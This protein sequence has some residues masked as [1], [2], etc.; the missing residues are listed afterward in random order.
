MR[1]FFTVV[2]TTLSL[3]LLVAPTLSIAEV[4]AYLNRYTIN[5]TDTVRLTIEA[6]QPG[7]AQRPDL[8]L[9]TAD[10]SL[11]GSKKM[12]ISSLQNGSRQATTRWQVLMR[13]RRSGDLTVPA[14]QINGERSFPMT[15]S[16]LSAANNAPRVPPNYDPNYSPNRSSSSQANQAPGGLDVTSDLNAIRITTEID[17]TEAY[18]GSQLLYSSTLRHRSPLDDQAVFSDPFLNQALIL[19]MGDEVVSN[20]FIQG[21]AYT[22]RKQTYVVFPNEPGSFI[23]EPPLF[24]GTLAN[25]QYVEVLGDA[26][27]LS[28]LP[29]ANDNS[30]GY[31]LPA[32]KLTIQDAF[33]QPE[34]LIAGNSITRTIT[35]IAQGLPASRLPPMMPLTNELADI[36]L[37]N[38]DLRESFN[39]D[40]L[41]GQRVE[42]VKITFKERGEVTLPPIDIHWWDIETDRAQVAS[43]PPIQMRIEGANSA[44][45][46]PPADQKNAKPDL[47][48]NSNTTQS[49]EQYSN[50]TPPNVIA[51]IALLALISIISSLGWLYTGN[52]LRKLRNRQ[53][54]DRAAKTEKQRIKRDKQLIADEKLAYS[55]LQKACTLNK[56]ELAQARLIEW[57]ALFWPESHLYNGRDVSVAAKNK[58][59]EFLIIDLEQHVYNNAEDPWQGDLLIQTVD[60]IRERLTRR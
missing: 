20:V 54:I 27:E 40:G 9:L 52:R 12:T 56:P 31:W 15:L 21:V 47:A 2:S 10:F 43:L 25:G 51:L 22:E 14:I 36:E 7:Q 11:L 38:T 33:D 48:E 23:I 30:A 42:T 1:A 19:P 6:T 34:Q 46:Q 41:V 24:A 58:T 32:S 59:L 8:S 57:A 37:V 45:Q 26:I 60:S 5:Q 35:L 39:E 28:I 53:A 49:V 50:G 3:L 17:H 16:V 18:E 4:N 44:Q 55:A 29:R 13:P